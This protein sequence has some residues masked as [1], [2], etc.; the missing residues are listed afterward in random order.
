MPA[1]DQ[2]ER[3]VQAIADARQG[4]GQLT[5]HHDLPRRRRDVEERSIDI[6]QD[7]QT[8]EIAGV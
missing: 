8:T 2:R 4:V 3:T 1:A 5:G 6:E 7:G